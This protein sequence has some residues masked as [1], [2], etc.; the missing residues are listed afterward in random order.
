MFTQNAH[1]LPG[2]LRLNIITFG[3]TLFLVFIIR[4][5]PTTLTSL[6]TRYYTIF[7][8]LAINVGFL[9]FLAIPHLLSENEKL[10]MEHLNSGNSLYYQRKYKKALEEYNL[11]ENIYSEDSQLYIYKAYCYQKQKEYAKSNLPPSYEQQT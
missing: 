6:N 3:I 5:D 7:G 11:A 10:Y 9:I 8:I 4:Y 1:M 2:I